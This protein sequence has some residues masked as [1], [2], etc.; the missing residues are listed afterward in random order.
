MIMA[1]CQEAQKP[2]PNFRVQLPPGA[3]P[4]EYLVGRITPVGPRRPEIKQ[5]HSGQDITVLAFPE[6]ERDTRFN[7]RYIKSISDI[8][9]KF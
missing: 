5:R 8:L 1:I 3:V 2:V 9:G 6:F 7:L 4:I